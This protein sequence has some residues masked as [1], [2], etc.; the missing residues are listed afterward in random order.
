MILLTIKEFKTKFLD[1]K[2]TS[3]SLAGI[4][5]FNKWTVMWG[6]HRLTIDQFQTCFRYLYKVT[7]VTKLRGFQYRLLHKHIP[8]NNEL[9]RWKLKSSDECGNCKE[10]NDIMHTMYKCEPIKNIWE[11][12]KLYI[13]K[14]FGVCPAIDEVSII[15]NTFVPCPQSV[16]NLL[17]LV[18]K[19]IIYHYKCKHKL[20]NFTMFIKEIEIIEQIEFYNAYVNNKVVIHKAK[21]AKEH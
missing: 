1:R 16:V 6:E 4:D 15:C 9:Y 12:W 3:N 19:Q 20:M 10:P 11:Q 5:A 14:Q 17:G 7:N 2:L 18:L 21:W 13:I 8:T